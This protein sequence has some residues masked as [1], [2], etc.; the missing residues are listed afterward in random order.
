M[1]I[2]VGLY[3]YDSALLLLPNEGILKACFASQ[4]R[5]SFGSKNT[6]FF[7][8]ELYLPNLFGPATPIF[9]LSWKYETSVPSRTTDWD[10]CIPTLRW[11]LVPTWLQFSFSFVLLPLALFG[12]FGDSLLLAVFALIYLCVALIVVLLYFAKAALSIGSREFWLTALDLL[13]CPP[14]AIN[15]VRRLSLRQNVTEDFVE[16]AR[17]LEK[18]EHWRETEIELCKRLLDEVNCEEEDTPRAT[19]L[20]QRI[21][22]LKPVNY[23]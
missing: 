3:I 19:A 10:S 5:S 2:Y 7:G 18:P 14:F 15:V 16:A 13:I 4:W 17:R 1:G 6:T 8:K 9:R 20:K 23:D 21:A 22:L 12:H 11:F